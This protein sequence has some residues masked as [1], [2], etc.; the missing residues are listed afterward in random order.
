MA[1]FPSLAAKAENRL[2]PPCSG[3]GLTL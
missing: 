2:A 1:G 3:A